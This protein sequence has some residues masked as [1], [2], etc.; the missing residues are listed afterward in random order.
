MYQIPILLVFFNREDVVMRTFE[1]IREVQPT[2]LYL[3]SDGPRESRPGERQIVED[4]R[5]RL[6]K[7]IDWPCDVRTRFLEENVGCSLGVSTAINWLFENEE[8]GIILEDDCLPQRSFFPFMAEMLER[9]KDD[10]R[11]GMVDGANYIRKYKIKDSY[12]FSKYKSTNGWG[13][14][15]RSWKNMDLDM[16]WRGTHYEPSI[17][18]NIGYCAVDGRYWR[19]RLRAVDCKHVSAWDWQWYFTLSAQNQLSVFPKVSLI[20]NI[21]FGE[22]ATHTAFNVNQNR[23]MATQELE[24]PLQHPRYVVPDFDFDRCFYKNNNTLYNKVNQLIPFKIKRKI[25][26]FLTSRHK[27]NG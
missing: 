23:Y 1:R 13:T 24:F 12:C 3:A 2:K 10:Q 18:K 9:Y 5:G 22:G 4:L 11:I 8:V 20:S 16:T 25:K 14:W 19:Y 6:L 26:S 21:G 15:R 27:N 7:Q 17:I